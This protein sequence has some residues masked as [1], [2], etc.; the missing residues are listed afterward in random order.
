MEPGAEIHEEHPFVPPPADRDAVRR[1]R[2]RLA[3]PVTLW[4]AGTG[5]A[6]AGLTV[7]SVLVV[8][9]EPGHVVGMVDPDSDLADAVE[10]VGR[11]TVQ[12]LGPDQQRL[13]DQF[14]GVMPA[15]GG[16]FAQDDWTDTEWGPVLR[17]GAGWLGC[18][19][20]GTAEVGWSSRVDAT[21][22]R[23]VLAADRSA[24]AYLRGRY[25][26]LDPR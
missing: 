19:L 3:A 9:G 25:H 14:G 11:F 10:Q 2:G 4:A 6:R 21:I 1:F 12:L 20:D 26:R 17:D 18:R 7:A 15:P 13:A 22:E 8:E 23:V 5:R 24:L 16:L